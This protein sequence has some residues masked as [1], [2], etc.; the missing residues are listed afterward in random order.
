MDLITL[1]SKDSPEELLIYFL[2]STIP[3]YVEV[4]LLI[5]HFL[6][7][8]YCIHLVPVLLTDGHSDNYDFCIFESVVFLY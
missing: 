2:P 8:R 1:T 7:T 6:S 5:G 3:Q 4:K